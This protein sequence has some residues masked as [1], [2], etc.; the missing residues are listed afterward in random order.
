MTQWNLG[1]VD[2]VHSFASIPPGEYEVRIV[3]VRPGQ[4]KD[5]S[6]RWTLRLEVATGDYAGRTAAWD[7]LTWSER[8]VVR[9]KHVLAALGYDVDGVVDVQPQDLLGRGARVQVITEEF[10]S[11]ATGQRVERM[12]VP[13]RGWT[14]WPEGAAPVRVG[15]SS[16]PAPAAPRLEADTA[17]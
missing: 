15:A 4:A 8:G 12:A 11:P 2:T 3:D 5:K 14:P 9:V 16:A 10:E 13:F 7:S 17:F 1:Q 6:E